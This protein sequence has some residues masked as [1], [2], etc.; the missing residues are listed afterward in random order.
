MQ[1]GFISGSIFSKLSL[2]FLWKGDSCAQV[3]NKT[4]GSIRI[5]YI[6]LDK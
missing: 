6:D 3:D 2:G 1:K 4:P 5:T